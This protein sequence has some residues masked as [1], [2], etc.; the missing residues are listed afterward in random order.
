[1]NAELENY[2]KKKS[3]QKKF[4]FSYFIIFSSFVKKSYSIHSFRIFSS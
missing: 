2:L 3:K 4:S 1:M